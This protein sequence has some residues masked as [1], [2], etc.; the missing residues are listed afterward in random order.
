MDAVHDNQLP[1]ILESLE[2]L[3]YTP[4]TRVV[5][6]EYV[7][8]DYYIN[9]AKKIY[10]V[11]YV[12]GEILDSLYIEE[13]SVEEYLE[14]T[15]SYL[16]TLGSVVDIWEIGNEINRDGLG[17]TF[18]VIEKITGAYERVKQRGGRSALTLYYNQDCFKNEANEMFKWASENIPAAMK[19]GLDYVLISYYEDDCNDLQPD[20]LSIFQRLAQMFPNS[21][22]G[23]GEIGTKH[24]ERKITYIQRYYGM[25]LSVPRYIRGCFWWYGRQDFVPWT[26]PLW[27][28]LN[29][30]IQIDTGDAGPGAAPKG[31]GA[32]RQE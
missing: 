21:K 24:E 25:H 1:A 7:E 5:F 15:D 20:W 23:F 16:D 4:T 2:K 6:D 13:Y 29:D 22:L 30:T 9:A 32:G 12:M 17:D 3:A 27:T 14:R 10:Q 18:S 19:R 26:K 28:T 11:S 8:P 31:I